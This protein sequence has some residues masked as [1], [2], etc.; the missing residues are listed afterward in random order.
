[1]QPENFTISFTVDQTPTE[2]FNA[3]TNV[4]G[5]WSEALDGSSEKLNDEFSYRHG[6]LHYSKHRLIEVIPNEKVVWLTLDSKLSFV[7]D[8]QEWNGTKMFFEI[9]KQDG[10]TSLVVTHQGLVPEF[11]CFNS[12]SRGWTHYLQNSLLPLITTGKGIPDKAATS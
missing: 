8:Q 6:D 9:S 1:M 4:R 2:V 3:I 7:K 11:E 12:C 5:W 10:K